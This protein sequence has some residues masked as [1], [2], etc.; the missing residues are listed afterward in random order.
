MKNFK[1]IKYF[2]FVVLATAPLLC[3]SN[4]NYTPGTVTLYSNNTFM[5]GAYNVR[6][7]PAVS[8]GRVFVGLDPGSSLTI[9]GTSS[10]TGAGFFCSLTSLDSLFAKA[11]KAVLSLGNGSVLI[12]SRGSTT[13]C[14]NVQI[15]T[16]SD[17]LD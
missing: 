4:G 16:G 7:N 13:T 2:L 15:Q 17:S 11:E 8:T 9:S 14:T 6:Y 12:A 5:V 1:F 10:S 3:W